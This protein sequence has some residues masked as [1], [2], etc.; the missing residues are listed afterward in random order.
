MKVERVNVYLVRA[1]RLHPVIVEIVCDEGIAGIG[2]AAIAYGIG[3]TAAA[4]MVK[5]LAERMIVGRD[6]AQIEKLWSEMYDH[7]FWAKGG[8]AI[9]FAAMSGIEQALWDIK[10]QAL[11]V[12]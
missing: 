9:V 10:G 12:A 11:G 8:G 1:G 3:G 7:S 5:D 4:G 2:E 6:P